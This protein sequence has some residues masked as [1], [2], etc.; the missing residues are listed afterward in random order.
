MQKEDDFDPYAFAQ[1]RTREKITRER[2]TQS[3][4][5]DNPN[6]PVQVSF[7]NIFKF[8]K[9]QLRTTRMR[10]MTSPP[11]PTVPI[12]G[13]TRREGKVSAPR[14]AYGPPQKTWRE[15]VEIGEAAERRQQ[16]TWHKF[17][18]P[19]SKPIKKK[20]TRANH[21]RK[22]MSDKKHARIFSRS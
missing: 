14:A 11:P 21:N 8:L 9:W 15:C 20:A 7:F 22:A 17:F 6:L 10:R 19:N 13:H 12:R 2:T 4:L 16:G 1:A 5:A 18:K 3:N